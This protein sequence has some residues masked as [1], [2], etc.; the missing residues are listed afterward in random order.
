MGLAALVGAALNFVATSTACE[1]LAL[2]G[3]PMFGVWGAPTEAHDLPAFWASLVI[4][5]AEGAR[6]FV[7][8]RG[9]GRDVILIS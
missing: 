4:A 1:G 3:V 8:L 6:R 2:V 5:R 7:P 9:H